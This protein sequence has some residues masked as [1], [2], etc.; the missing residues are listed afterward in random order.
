M[1]LQNQLLDNQTLFCNDLN[2]KYNDSLYVVFVTSVR[3]LER[4]FVTLT[5][6][7]FEKLSALC[8]N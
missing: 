5:S 4:Y 6:S 8:A 1:I 2:T 3:L 7:Y